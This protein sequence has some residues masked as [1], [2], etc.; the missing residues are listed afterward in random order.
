MWIWEAQFKLCFILIFFLFST[1]DSSAQKQKDPVESK[2]KVFLEEI[3][4][5]RFSGR[6]L[7]LSDIKSKL[8]AL[9][10]F[11]C[12]GKKSLLINTFNLSQIPFPRIQNFNVRNLSRY[13]K[14]VD[15]VLTMEKVRSF[16]GSFGR[17]ASMEE[18]LSK[19]LTSKC[20]LGPYI[21]WSSSQRD[22]LGLELYLQDRFLNLP[23]TS[24]TKDG[25]GSFFQSFDK[26]YPHEW[27]VVFN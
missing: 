3:A 14:L 27:L 11:R 1:F 25:I 26:R 16:A 5:A 4:V 20:R 22:I 8:I 18:F 10:K 12:F 19:F 6:V 7:F 15:I 9:R 13:K 17:R 24:K 2:N 23:K 21:K